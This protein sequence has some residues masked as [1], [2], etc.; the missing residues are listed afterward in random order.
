V[1]ATGDP[2]WTRL[3]NGLTVSF[4]DVVT[5]AEPAALAGTVRLD[6]TVEAVDGWTATLISGATA[7]LTDG[8]ATAS[9]QLDPAGAAALLQ[10][11]YDEVGV[12]GGTATLTVVPRVDV[13]GTVEGRPFRAAAPAGLGFA[14]DE[15][16]LRLAGEAAALAP[17]TE[18]AVAVDR[19]APRA[20]SFGAVTVPVGV[21]RI[22]AGVVLAV[23][24]LVL[25]GAAWIGRSPRGDTTDDFLVRHAARILPVTSLVTGSTVIDVTDAEALHRVAERLDSLVL[26]QSSPYGHT[27]AVQDAETTYRYVVSTPPAPRPAPRRTSTAS[28]LSRFA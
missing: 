28:I 15:T 11:H 17:T 10:R 7:P 23:A 27:F 18:T 12:S 14:L 16:A 22:A 13:T 21:V 6:V 20:F 4:E 9:V 24:L 8:S 1:I 26:H 25:A 19:I 2:I 3:T 5:G